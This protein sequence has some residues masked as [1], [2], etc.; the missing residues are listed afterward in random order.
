MASKFEGLTLNGVPLSEVLETGNVAGDPKTEE[1]FQE[2]CREI[3]RKGR[4]STST[5]DG[6]IHTTGKKIKEKPKPFVIKTKIYTPEEIQEYERKR[7]MNSIPPTPSPSSTPSPTPSS[8]RRRAVIRTT[9]AMKTFR[10]YYGERKYTP[11][12]TPFEIQ[13]MSIVEKFHYYYG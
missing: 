10:K 11:P 6:V 13:K 7:K 8:S 5:P 4:R 3:F 9:S 2:L 1:I 12:M